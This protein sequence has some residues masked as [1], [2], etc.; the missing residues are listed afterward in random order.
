MLNAWRIAQRSSNRNSD[1]ELWDI[2]HQIVLHDVA[3]VVGFTDS[4]KLAKILLVRTETDRNISGTLRAEQAR[5]VLQLLNVIPH[6]KMTTRLKTVYTS[7]CSRARALSGDIPGALSILQPITRKRFDDDQH[8]ASVVRAYNTVATCIAREKGPLALL[9]MITSD[10]AFLH[11]YFDASVP[12]ESSAA[13]TSYQLR[14]TVLDNIF[15][16]EDAE[17]LLA[18]TRDLENSARGIVSDLMLLAGM[19]RGSSRQALNIFNQMNQKALPMSEQ[20][21]LRL[22]HVLTREE[23]FGV[24]RQVMASFGNPGSHASSHYLRT[25]LYLCAHSGDIDGAEEYYAA[26][27][28]HDWAG[29]REVTLRMHAHA[30]RGRTEHTTLLFDEYYPKDEN[31]RRKNAP[32]LQAFSTVIHAHSKKGDIGGINKWLAEMLENGH[33]PDSHVYNMILAAFASRGEMRSVNDILRQMREAGHP[34]DIVSYSALLSLLA[35]RADPVAAEEVYKQALAEGIRPNRRLI[36]SLMNAH[37]NAGSWKGVIRVFNYLRNSPEREAAM[38]IEV[39]NTLLKAYVLIAAPFHVVSKLF[40]QL[41][42]TN[43]RPD[44]VTYALLIQS[45]CDAAKMT[46]AHDIFNELDAES[47]RSRWESH[48]RVDA[49]ALTMIMAA[50]L[51]LKKL[52]KAKEVYDNMIERGISP[53]STTY[54]AII[55]SYANEGS[56]QSLHTA[57]EFIDA[58]ADKPRDDKEWDKHF[59]GRGT[60]LESI[61]TPLLRAYKRKQSV[62]DV[63]NTIQSLI[64]QGGEPSLGTHALMLDCYRRTKDINNLIAIWPQIFELGVKYMEESYLTEEKPDPERML[65]SNILCIP[66]SIYIEGLSHAGRHEKIPEVWKDYRAAGMTFDSHNW[67]HL[68]VALVRAGQPERAFQVIEHVVLPYRA[69]SRRHE[70][71]TEVVADSPLLFDVGQ[72]EGSD[73]VFENLQPSGESVIRSNVRRDQRSHLQEKQ[74]PSHTFPD[75]D[76]ENFTS[77]QYLRPLEVLNT[78]SPSWNIW[79]P[80]DVTL[81]NLG[82]ALTTLRKGTVIRP[83][84]YRP[85]ED[86]PVP[87]VPRSYEQATVEELEIERKRA[88]EIAVRLEE[89]CPQT[90]ALVERQKNNHLRGRISFVEGR[91]GV[92]NLM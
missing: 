68:C 92:R 59:W 78:I 79:R 63:E 65:R 1:S 64:E 76:A 48:A 24:A 47:N 90:V 80:H 70:S 67:N 5:N 8:R 88:L 74:F 20:L 19:E 49:Y 37:V 91:F 39:Y 53:N 28:A 25:A 81:R 2:C 66:L 89:T 23:S 26:L 16:I 38:T 57:H 43:V 42:K 12:H 46:I 72:E 15:S 30:T 35:H 62:E 56:E 44:S 21:R 61:Y 33:T 10:W 60:A 14:R 31:G 73:E 54:N 29:A 77:D 7:L 82:W 41:E 86:E 52:D 40:L 84:Q 36:S 50:W 6:A 58:L 55:N 71:V 9:D 11:P 4:L 34:P 45:A 22:V 75:L 27:V 3:G 32:S 18:Y 51:R 13:G 87:E 85:G 83:N 69:R 17:M